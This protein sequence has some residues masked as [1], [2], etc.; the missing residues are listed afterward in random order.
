MSRWYRAYEGTVTDAKLHEAAMVAGVS[1]SVAIA[2]W[3]AILEACAAAKSARFDT[4]PRRIAVI[5]GEPLSAIEG[6]FAALAEL[7]MILDGEATAWARRQFDSDNSTERS[8]K[9]REHRRNGD[10]TLQGRSATPPETDTEKK[11]TTLL[12]ARDLDGLEA[13]CREAAGAEQNPSPSL[14]DLSPVVR[15]LNAGADLDADVL[16]TIRQ[17]TA[18]RH[19]WQSWRYAEQAIMDAKAS[20]EAP[21][22]VGSPHAPRAPPD[23]PKTMNRRLIEALD[24]MD[25]SN[26]PLPDPGNART[27]PPSLPS[28]VHD[29]FGG[30]SRGTG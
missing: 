3:H 18:R 15:C 25:F 17:I 5:L 4:T 30:R 27:I 2:S 24:N 12:G 13:K 8:R 16:P 7:G 21:A 28:P 11:D 1:R 22:P 19:R 26:G 10:A 23:K 9:H 6:L 20:R 29:V 14:L